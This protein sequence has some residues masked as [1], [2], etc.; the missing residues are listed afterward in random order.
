MTLGVTVGELERRPRRTATSQP[1]TRI[2][3]IPASSGAADD[4]VAVGVEPLVLEMGVRVDEPV[5]PLRSAR[6]AQAGVSSS[7][8][9]K[10]GVGAPVRHGVG[11][12]PHAVST[13]RPGPAVAAVV[14]RRAAR[15]A[16]RAVGAAP[17][18]ATGARRWP[19][20]RHASAMTASTWP[21]RSVSPALCSDHGAWLSA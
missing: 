8:R 20:M 3:S 2:R 15:P 18:G 4:R 16:A 9:G 14:V 13:S 19:M 21:T 1:G 6:T 11:P 12:L 7:T 5:Q 17:V 10:I